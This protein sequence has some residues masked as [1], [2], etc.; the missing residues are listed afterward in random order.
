MPEDD[1]ERTEA[2]SGK[3]REEARQK[4]Q[5]VSSREVTSMAILLGGA[6][7]LSQLG[8][9]MVINAQ[10]VMVRTWSSFP[11]STMTPEGLYQV[12]LMSLKDSFIILGPIVVLLVA[13]AVFSTILQ[14]G[15]L[16]TTGPLAP[17]WSRLDPLA[18]FGRLFSMKSA[19]ELF[20]TLFKF[21]AVG[22]LVYISVRDEIPTL[23]TAIQNQPVQMLPLAGEMIFQLV[24][25]AG[26]VV[27]IIG[28]A[29][30]GYNWW[31][32]EKGLKMSRKEVK[33]E[34]KQAEGDPMVKARIRT[35]QR[36]M[37]RKRMMAEVPKAEVII[38]NP[39]HLAIALMYKPET[40]EAPTV[41]AKGAGFIAQTI[42]EI[43]KAHD[44]PIIENKPLARDLFG[45]VKVGEQ[46]PYTFYRAVAE[47]LAYVFRLRGRQP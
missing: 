27:A 20:K 26:L 12:L 44:I 13:I 35:A 33:D 31:E 2:P 3:R 8:T 38:T 7:G 19:A 34:A 11:S 24:L 28:V 47:I 45:A 17:N 43:A 30:Y 22:Y 6:W 14:H 25:S 4:G 39:T 21:L 29:D 16:W 41:V 40:M 32:H 37:A 10:E 1:A 15:W 9:Q 42:R 46:V 36:Q 23:L 18:G 5:V